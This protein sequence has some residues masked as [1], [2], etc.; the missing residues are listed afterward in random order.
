[1]GDLVHVN[2]RAQANLEIV[3]DVI[4]GRVIT[5]ASDTGE[6]IITD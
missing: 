5:I 1:V 4:R 3:L 6:P 2:T